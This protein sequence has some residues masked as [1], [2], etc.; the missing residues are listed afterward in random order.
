[1]KKV[2]MILAVLAVSIPLYAAIPA[3]ETHS[4]AFECDTCHSPHTSNPSTDA[5]L[6]GKATGTATA[7]YANPNSTMKTAGGPS[8]PA[9]VSLLCMS[10]H[11]G[12]TTTTGTR[13]EK[14]DG[15]ASDP[16]VVATATTHPIS[17]TYD[18]AALNTAWG[19]TRYVASPDSSFL[20]GGKVECASCHDIHTVVNTDFLRTPTVGVEI[21][22]DCH[23]K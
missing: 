4:E 22:A 7:A 11:D 19:D 20:V 5:P 14:I 23:I 3:G 16:G 13:G 21:C 8:Q 6:W 2:L 15:A 18:G 17:I 9:D 10:C 1:M 12:V